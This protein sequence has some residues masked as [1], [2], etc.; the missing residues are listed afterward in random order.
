MEYLSSCGQSGLLLVVVL[1]LLADLVSL[2]V[3]PR[4]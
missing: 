1:R 3:D 4:L 2:V